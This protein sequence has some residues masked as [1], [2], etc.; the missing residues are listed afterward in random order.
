[1]FGASKI[2]GSMDIAK[3]VLQGQAGDGGVEES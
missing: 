2:L 3:Q 1:M